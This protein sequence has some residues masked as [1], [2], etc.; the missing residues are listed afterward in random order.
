ML[1]SVTRALLYWCV[2]YTFC[3]RMTARLALARD[4][5]L[6]HD[7]HLVDALVDSRRYRYGGPHWL[8]R[9]TWQLMPK[10]DIIILLDAPPE[11][12]QARKQEVA[13]EETARQ[14]RAYLSLMETFKNGHV[15]DASRP[16]RLVVSDVNDIILRYLMTRIVNRLGLQQIEI[17]MDKAALHS[18]F[19]SGTS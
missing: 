1:A 8:L 5:L 13:F 12:L 10:P 18:T 15:V 9:F 6:I 19:G 11:V 16:L 2:F 4:T 14:R 3:Y 17:C 7:R